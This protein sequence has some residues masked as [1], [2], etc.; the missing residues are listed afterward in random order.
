MMGLQHLP[1][2]VGM[3]KMRFSVLPLVV[4]SASIPAFASRLSF[5]QRV[6]AQRAIE[7]VYYAHQIGAQR[8]FDQAVPTGLLE[9][10]VRTYLK[11][12]EAL[13][14]LWHTPVTAE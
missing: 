9:R 11:Q 1:D 8:P 7:R 13:E 14:R 4:L 10:R 5:Q 6:E 2:E 12:S 3:T